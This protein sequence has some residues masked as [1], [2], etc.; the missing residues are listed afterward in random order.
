MGA[1]DRVLDRIASEYG[2][3]V[4]PGTELYEWLKQNS[5]D[6]D[7][8]YLSEDDQFQEL[9]ERY[10]AREDV[11]ELDDTFDDFRASDFGFF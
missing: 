1:W 8:G 6:I 9:F 2:I 11:P 10:Q 5:L 3:E 4:E 7:S